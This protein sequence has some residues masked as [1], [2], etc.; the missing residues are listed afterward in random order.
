MDELDRS[1]QVLK[2]IKRVGEKLKKQIHHQ[3]GEMNLTAP[4]GMLVGILCK[5]GPCRVSELSEKMMLSNSTVSGIID[6]LEK[7]GHV[8]RVKG[9]ED[10]R[11]VTVKLA[12]DFKDVMNQRSGI[13]GDLMSKMIGIASTEEVEEIISGLKTL[14][15]VISRYSEA[16][17]TK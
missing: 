5:E 6:R 13:M 14:D 9:V 16:E 3:Y 11:I 10:R 2:L 1:F 15:L 12:D 17:G 7:S 4:Q 8:E